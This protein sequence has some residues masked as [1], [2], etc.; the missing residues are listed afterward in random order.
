MLHEQRRGLVHAPADAA[1]QK[2]R[3]LQE[4]ATTVS[5]PRFSQIQRE[6]PRAKTPAASVAAAGEPL[7][8]LP[9]IPGCTGRRGPNEYAGRR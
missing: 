4:L 6:K 9:A 7:S 3:P 5:A 1:G 2:P 8:G